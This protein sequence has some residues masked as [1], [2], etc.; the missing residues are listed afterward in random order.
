MRLNFLNESA[1]SPS[2]LQRLSSSQ[3]GG[4]IGEVEWAFRSKSK[5]ICGRLI[6]NDRILH[7]AGYDAADVAFLSLDRYIRLTSVMRMYLLN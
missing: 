4:T 1:I 5:K 7:K 3:T 6:M 2:L